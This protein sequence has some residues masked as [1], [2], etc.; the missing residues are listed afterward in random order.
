M[1]KSQSIAFFEE[2]SKNQ[3]LAQE[4]EKVVGGKNSDEAKAKELISLAKE[5]GFNFT[6]DELKTS[7][8]VEDLADVSGG[9]WSSI[10]RL[11]L[12]VLNMFGFGGGGNLP[13]PQPVAPIVNVQQAA[14]DNTQNQDRQQQQQLYDATL[15][16]NYVDAILDNI[17]QRPSSLIKELSQ[18]LRSDLDRLRDDGVPEELIKEY[19]NCL[20][21]IISTGKIDS[22]LFHTVFAINKWLYEQGKPSNYKPSEDCDAVERITEEARCAEFYMGRLVDRAIHYNLRDLA[23]DVAS[24]YA[25]FVVGYRALAERVSANGGVVDDAF[26]NELIALHMEAQNTY[27]DY[28]DAIDLAVRE[29]EEREREREAR[30]REAREIRAR[31]NEQLRRDPRWPLRLETVLTRAYNHDLA[32]GLSVEEANANRERN[33]QCLMDDPAEIDGFE[34]FI[35][36]KIIKRAREEREREAREIRARANEQLRNDPSWSSRVEAVLT[37]AY[38][39]DLALGLSEAAANANRERDRQRLMAD[40]AEIDAFEAFMERE[41]EARE[42]VARERAA[43]ESVARERAAREREVRERANEQLRNDP[44]WSSRLE[45]V[46]TRSYNHDL[47]LGLSEAFAND[48][49]ELDRQ[50]L[51]DNPAE[52]D[53][54]EEETEARESLAREREEIA[55]RAILAGKPAQQNDLGAPQMIRARENQYIEAGQ[56][57]HVHSFSDNE[58]FHE[59]AGRATIT[60][61]GAVDIDVGDITLTVSE[62]N[63]EDLSRN[64]TVNRANSLTVA[65]GITMRTQNGDTFVMRPTIRETVEQL[66]ASLNPEAAKFICEKYLNSNKK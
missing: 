29:A 47:A 53:A 28:D 30:E 6:A 1:S 2:I 11:G 36:E 56:N 15:S 44:N 62:C 60:G 50:R 16:Y 9:M 14:N 59:G 22:G 33:R 27:Y 43:R 7:L 66:L 19:A 17:N 58:L 61:T 38:N 31:A 40:P 64:V 10:G 13:A 4:V 63:E 65:P 25:R 41:I 48:N 26:L 52:I 49:R 3:Q 54:F 32:L 35:E 8:S 34:A 24:T 12:S 45:A 46:L 21:Q 42:S 5:H 39:H 57:T 37:Q 23:A 55:A 18:N 51:M 20:Q